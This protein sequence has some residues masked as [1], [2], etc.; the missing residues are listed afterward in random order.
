MA[1][2]PA[3]AGVDGGTQPVRA[4]ALLVV[5]VVLAAFCVIGGFVVLA[6]LTDHPFHYFSKEPAESLDADLYIGWFAHLTAVVWLGA[7]ATALFAGV[8][9]HRSGRR[10]HAW[11]LLAGG[12]LSTL[13]GAD[14]LFLLHEFVYPRVGIPQEAVY[15]AYGVLLAAYVWRFRPEILADD[16][17]T[18]L[19][20]GAF[21]A[22]A[23][24][25]DVVQHR[26]GVPHVVE[27]GA[28][29]IGVAL[30]STFL[31]RAAGRHVLAGFNQAGP[32]YA[33]RGEL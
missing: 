17:L 19:V 5:S 16:W 1:N 27:D 4:Q 6:A 23:T 33:G 20:A 28:K 3:S 26:W 9:L 15:L 25:S 7:A 12:A 14:D 18:L 31:V 22:T 24:S 29:L 32:A 13:L 21:F 11:F 30:W 8:T 10:R 2:W